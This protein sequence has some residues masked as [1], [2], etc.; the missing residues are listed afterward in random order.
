MTTMTTMSKASRVTGI[1]GQVERR[2]EASPT[3]KTNAPIA[4]VTPEQVRT[5][6]FEIY[7]ARCANGCEGDALSDWVRAEQELNGRTPEPCALA[8][9]EAKSLA[10]G[11][12]LLAN[13]VE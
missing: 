10:R 4:D 9:V 3:P 2:P 11:E 13:P 12:E 1:L 6:A 8:E 7:K 5:R